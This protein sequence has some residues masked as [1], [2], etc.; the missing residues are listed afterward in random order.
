VRTIRWI[1]LAL[2]AFQTVSIVACSRGEKGAA[3]SGAP[4]AAVTVLRIAGPDAMVPLVQRWAENYKKTHPGVSVDV[5]GGGAEAGIAGLIDGT[6]DLG[7]ASREI[8]PPEIDRAI[9]K[10][11]TSPKRFIVALD[12]VSVYVHKD[13][14]LNAIAID[15]L[16]DI[17]GAGGRI[18]KWSQLGVK[19]AACETDSITRVGRQSNSGTSE[20]FQKAV[21][22][23]TRE[24]KPGSIDQSGSNEVVSLVSGTPCAIGYNSTLYAARDVKT[25]QLSKHKK[26]HPVALS[27]ETARDMTYPLVRAL[28][29]YMP[30]KPK[31][32]AMQ[33]LFW[34]LSVDGQKHVKDAGFIPLVDLS[35]P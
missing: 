30:A 7:A 9:K 1:P 6:L 31:P 8:E 4:V 5:A 32:G 19:N 18:D 17:Y 35:G 16:A 14:P 21:L 11:G 2:I 3:E 25:L 22:G 23:A 28:Y 24:Y 12:A 26:E 10:D 15:D 34:A 33:F 13:N 27:N 20:Y 29:F